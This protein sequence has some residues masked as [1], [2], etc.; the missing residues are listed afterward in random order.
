M[1]ADGCSEDV[2]KPILERIHLDSLGSP[3]KYRKMAETDGLELVEFDELTE[4][5]TIHYSR[6]LAETESRRN[7]L[8][9]AVSEEYITRMIKGLNHWIDGS[10]KGWLAWGIMHFRKV[11]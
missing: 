9:K 4:Q 2:L 7:D 8:R 10:R 1:Q 5:L 11:K 3:E 6:V